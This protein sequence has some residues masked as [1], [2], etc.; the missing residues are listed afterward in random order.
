MQTEVTEREKK[1]LEKFRKLPERKQ[2]TVDGFT[3][4]LEIGSALEEKELEECRKTA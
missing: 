2:A 4:G 1:L 3:E